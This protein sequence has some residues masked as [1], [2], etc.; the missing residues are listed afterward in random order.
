MTIRSEL[1]IE[2]DAKSHPF[3]AKC[4]L[5]GE[6]MPK[7]DPRVTKASEMILWFARQFTLHKHEKHP[8]EGA[9]KTAA[10]LIQEGIDRR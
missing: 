2:Y 7:A 10:R 4:T 5:C 8:P 1:V 9:N 6:E 3:T